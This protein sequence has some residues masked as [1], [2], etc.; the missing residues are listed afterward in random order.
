MG[1]GSSALVPVVM[2]VAA[3]QGQSERPLCPSAAEGRP[4]C[5]AESSAPKPPMIGILSASSCITSNLKKKKTQN[6]S[7]DVINAALSASRQPVLQS[8]TKLL[9][10]PFHFSRNAPRPLAALDNTAMNSTS[11][12]QLKATVHWEMQTEFLWQ[13]GPSLK[14]LAGAFR[15]WSSFSDCQTHQDNIRS[16]GLCFP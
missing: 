3:C 9:L 16:H 2:G 15:G 1:V 7:C 4:E 13:P 8:W 10:S 12:F 11:E 14:C 5:A 6:A